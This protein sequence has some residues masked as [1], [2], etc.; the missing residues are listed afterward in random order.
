[1]LSLLLL[2]L[3]QSPS[4]VG[5]DDVLGQV[6]T[7]GM[8]IKL[9]LRG[10]KANA[11]VLRNMRKKLADRGL[12]QGSLAAADST[13]SVVAAYGVTH[14]SDKWLDQLLGT[15]ALGSGRFSIGSTACSEH[16]RPLNPPYADFGWHAF[17]VAGQTCFDIQIFTLKNGD[18][19][20]L[21]R[22]DFIKIVESARYAV[23]RVGDWSDYP[24]EYLDRSHEGLVRSETEG[25][26]SLVELAKTAPDAWA[27]SLA[28]AEIGRTLKHGADELTPLCQ[29]AIDG[30]AK[31]EK[32]SKTE[33]HARIV[34]LDAL[35]LAQRDAG[36][37]AEAIATLTH[38]RE[39]GAS[40]SVKVK[41]ALAYDLATAHAHDKD[42][43][44]A[45]A[46]LKEAFAGDPD[47]LLVGMRD[48]AFEPLHA[49]ANFQ[50]LFGLKKK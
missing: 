18:Q 35:G 23:V 4:V 27:C 15:M 24:L 37:S 19:A 45:I 11:D 47:R 50:E 2:S 16:E 34:A 49:D 42:A 21:K 20:P 26:S 32:P 7:T 36:K 30:L 6:A 44:S 38:A 33:L 12:I 1:M 10:Y 22:E 5:P 29:S 8:T 14:P 28:A 3:A 9:P 25:V 43:A 40:S 31:I 46:L 13:V 17:P 48:P 41:A 39:L